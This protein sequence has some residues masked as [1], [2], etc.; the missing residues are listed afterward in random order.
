MN[1]V[2]RVLLVTGIA[3]GINAALV[4]TDRVAMLVPPPEAVAEGF[5][6]NLAAQRPARAAPHL[7]ADARVLARQLPQFARHLNVAVGKIL[8]LETQTKYQGPTRAV[9]TSAVVGSNGQMAL[10][11]TLTRDA[12]RLWRIS[13]WRGA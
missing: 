11:L 4:A 8:K 12:Q 13:G 3:L 10:R 9:V 7:A 2:W 1:A 5:V 6:R